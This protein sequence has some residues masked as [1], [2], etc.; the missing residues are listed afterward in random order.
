M[1]A[2][3]TAYLVEEKCQVYFFIV[4][5]VLFLDS[6]SLKQMP[7]HYV[8]YAEIVFKQNPAILIREW[9]TTLSLAE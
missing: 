9:G 2:I 4:S 1:K 6:F 8:V 7:R 3:K 5:L